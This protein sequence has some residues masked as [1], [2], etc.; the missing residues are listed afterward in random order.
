[1]SAERHTIPDLIKAPK[2]VYKGTS[3]STQSLHPVVHHFALPKWLESEIMLKRICVSLLSLFLVVINSP[4]YSLTG[5]NQNGPQGNTGT[6]EK[7]IVASGSVAMDLDLNRLN[8]TGIGARESQPS[9]LRFDVENN[10][11]FT[12]LVF[13][14]ELRGAMP[15][16][17]G[18]IPQ[19]YVALPAKLD[20]S[21]HQLV[22]EKT[23][24]GEQFE[25]VVRDGKTGF[26][27]FNIEGHQF[28][29]DSNGHV[30]SVQA[31]RLLLSKE[32]ATEL[33]RPSEAGSI[34]GKISITATMRPVEITQMVNDEVRSDV[35]TARPEAGSVPGPDVIVGDLNG[36]TQPDTASGTQV[37]LAVGTDSCNLGTVD[38]DWFQTPVNDHPVIPQN[39]Y[40]M[41]GGATNDDRFEQ[42]GQSSVKHAFT[43]LTENICS[44]GCNGTGGTH[45]GSG[46]S[47]P[48]VASLNSGGSSHNLGSRA[49]INPFTG[50]YPRGDS[51]TPPNSHSGHTHNGTSHRIL[52]EVSDLNTTL[53]PGASYY[54]EAMYVTPHEYV[55][56]QSHVGQ[57]NMYNN[58]SYRRYVVS[59]TA[60]PFSFSTGGFTT[61]RTKPAIS[62]WT[63]ATSVQFEPD[64]GNDGIGLVAYKVTNPSPGVWHY[65]YAIFNQNLDRAIQSFSLPVGAGVTLNN[66]GF[67]APPQQP[68]WTFDG[69]VGN[70]G[71]SSTPWAQTQA[72]GAISWSSES[73]A[74]NP[75]ANAI[76]WG[77][78]Y[79]IRFDSNRPPQSINATLGFLKTGAPINVQ[80]Q[81]PSPAAQ[82]VS[83][84]GRVMR[85]NGQ[86]I[87]GVYVVITDSGGISRYT[88]T[89]SFGYYNFDN[90]VAGGTYTVEAASKRFTFTPQTLQINDNLSNL[91]FTAL[92]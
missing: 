52:V 47:D 18:L 11:F 40:R 32:F 31:G 28:D 76:R 56:C 43:A 30:L 38:L 82:N 62:A 83:V 84:S 54:A 7:M 80:V 8:G 77:T 5:L 55:W 29:Y 13:N 74:Q 45:L 91:D 88:L 71:F 50:V 41:S 21:S 25:L 46:C 68:G 75:N 14:D 33:G 27:F 24:W 17:M 60:S 37:G 44:L 78:L 23:A 20:A 3:K 85:S 59:G 22:I 72:G 48:Y 42:I 92:P 4:A 1:M 70:T 61:Q 12:I 49:W 73:F 64:P 51:A 81:G 26:V 34:V 79:N 16:S 87:G 9:V 6:L 15:S 53:N 67:H 2:R 63:G 10:S 86:G 65:E 90:V 57:C 36:L 89:G 19:N 35:L 39:F 58:V 66:V 69:T